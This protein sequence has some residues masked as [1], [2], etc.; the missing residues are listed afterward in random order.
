MLKSVYSDLLRCILNFFN[1]VY[2][3]AHSKLNNKVIV[4]KNNFNI[5]GPEAL[6]TNEKIYTEAINFALEN[7]NIKNIA[8]TGVYGAGKSSI[9]LTHIKSWKIE[10]NPISISLGNYDETVNQFEDFVQE[11]RVERQIINQI[12]S[13]ID[14][15]K[16]ILSKYN[17]KKNIS[18]ISAILKAV[19]YSMFILSILIWFYRNDVT[20]ILQ[21]YV[22]TWSISET[23]L[24]SIILFLVSIIT[25]FYYFTKE[26]RL[27]IDKINFKGAEAKFN[28]IVDT[29][30]TI[31]DRD[32]K[33]IVYLLYSSKVECVVFEDLDRYDNINIFTKLRE[34]NLLLN[35]FIL[36]NKKRYTVKFVYMLRDGLFLSKNRTKFFDFI[37]PVVPIVDSRTSEHI[38][39]ELFDSINFPPTKDVLAKIALYIDDMR[40]LKNI[41]NEYI[42]YSEV[43]QPKDIDLD[44]NKLFAIITLKNIFPNEF[45]LLQLN[46]GYIIDVF[47]RLDGS[48]KDIL[49]DLENK[50]QKIIE[51]ITWIKNRIESNRFDFMAIMIPSNISLNS[52]EKNISWS[53]VLKAWSEDESQSKVIFNGYN[54][55]WYDFNQFVNE[56][57]LTS[58]ARKSEFDD[59]YEDK[60]AQIKLLEDQLEKIN[61][62]FNKIDTYSYV[63]LLSNMN[64]EDREKIFTNTTNEIIMDYYFPLIRFLISEGLLDETY[65]YYKGRFNFDKSKLLGKNDV[66]YLKSLYESKQLDIGFKVNN[67]KEILSRLL[68][69]DYSRLNI[70]NKYI[71]KEVLN[72]GLEDKIILII[73]SLDKE[74]GYS[75]LA[76][77]LDDFDLEMI[78]K[79]IKSLATI[80][81]EYLLAILRGCQNN[82]INAYQKILV[83]LI[84]NKN[85]DNKFIGSFKEILEDN[86]QILSL[87]PANRVQTLI[88]HIDDLKLKFNDLTKI[89]LSR[90][91]LIIIEE[92]KAFNLNINNILLIT[93]IILPMEIEYGC[94]I[95][96]I[97]N[98]ECL[99]SSYEYI[100][101]NFDE[102]ITDYI[103]SRPEGITYYNDENFLTNLFSSKISNN[104]KIQY[105]SN[106]K[107]IITNAGA[108]N[109]TEFN[110]DVFDQLLITNTLEFNKDNLAYYWKNIKSYGKEFIDYLDVNINLDNVEAIFSLNKN[111]CNCII[112]DSDINVRLFEYL[113]PF[114]DKIFEE[115][116]VDLTAER[117]ERLIK[118]NLLAIT[119]SNIK[120]LIDREYYAEVI[121]FINSVNDIDKS[122]IISELLNYE[123][124]ESLIYDILNS[125]ISLD[126]VRP[127]FFKLK[128][129]PLIELIDPDRTEIVLHILN[130]YLSAANIEYISIKFSEFNLKNDFIKALNQSGQLLSF[131]ERCNNKIDILYLLNNNNIS[132]DDKIEI[133]KNKISSIN[134]NDLKEYILAI[135]E[136]S[137]LALIWEGKY[138]SVDTQY[139]EEIVELLVK[140]GTV[141]RRKDNKIML[142]S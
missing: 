24:V 3:R 112:T 60:K 80:E 54:T 89:E 12:I 34:L 19:F 99:K 11:N 81:E 109:I 17:F 118:K 96:N 116:E 5:L 66:I 25:F 82:Y 1:R 117:I 42:V 10:K 101:S 45:D 41:V 90:E 65:E 126:L 35:S 129:N 114:V 75:N 55:N 83:A 52:G 131:V 71:L 121:L 137:E 68:K 94:L 48:R 127:L 57:I 77:I 31:F 105:L 84:T 76:K 108:L 133:I 111:I 62:E 104:L 8:I 98:I 95:T 29:D 21:S 38:L 86:S 2:N 135:D 70:L 136:V 15:D 72:E 102:F 50:K 46:R 138:P 23:F 9:W 37:L 141:K 4:G 26:Y 113:L 88:K 53:K 140:L 13:Q 100:S 56:Y 142:Q 61:N 67:P 106:N 6:D 14:K 51:R 16:I 119:S 44:C 110:Q 107:Y 123:L 22:T 139:K 91:L 30:E 40:L 36:A 32:I 58:E 87:I 79:F 64:M 103:E 39:V 97:S 69:R 115:I 125:N 92:H 33:E 47:H 93:K 27:K 122:K 120:Y 74:S 73:K 132:I 7:N 18:C 43:I 28:D 63:D 20:V 134:E 59:L 124:D 49:S 78:D 130:N 128:E 85:I